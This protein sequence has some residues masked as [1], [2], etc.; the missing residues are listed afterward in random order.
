M[1]RLP[2]EGVR[3]LDMTV[4]WA[5]TYCATFMADMGADV[6]RIESVKSFAPITR[7]PSAHP[8]EAVLKSL[9]PF[10]GGMSGRSPGARPWNGSPCST[11]TPVIN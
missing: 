8:P 2:S 1:P 7:G 3:V 10:I 9:P 5:G 11:L 6:I 4:V